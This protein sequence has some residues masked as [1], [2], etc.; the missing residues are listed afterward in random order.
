MIADYFDKLSP[1]TQRRVDA[2]E[3]S[4]GFDIEVKVDTSRAGRYV[5]E[6]DPLA[7]SVSRTSATLILPSPDHF[8]NESVLHE[9]LHIER[10]LVHDVPQLE[11]CDAHWSPQLEKGLTNLDNM[12]EHLLIVPQELN[13]YP[14]R[15]EHWARII[16]LQLQ[17]LEQAPVTEQEKIV[18]A[19]CSLAFVLHVLSDKTLE[20]QVRSELARL[21]FAAQVESVA[22]LINASLNSK[23]SMANICIS[24]L[25][26]DRH[27][28]CLRYLRQ[29]RVRCFGES[30]AL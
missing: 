18:L 1:W 7:C 15:R 5:G 12:L 19:G 26:M 27:W 6:P 14:N 3:K 17:E 24:H 25:N 10:F 9:V 29:D 2:I 20:D 30:H 22:E 21:T 11:A 4:I 16:R 8:P 13:V 28:V 23:E